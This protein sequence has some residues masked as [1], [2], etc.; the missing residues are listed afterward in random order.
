MDEK[1]VLTIFE[2][3]ILYRRI[4]QVLLII[5]ALLTLHHLLGVKILG[6][7]MIIGGIILNLVFWKC[8]VCKKYLPMRAMSGSIKYCQGCGAKLQQP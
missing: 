2:K 8:P 3:R 7:I 6:G 4:S 5:G 1:E